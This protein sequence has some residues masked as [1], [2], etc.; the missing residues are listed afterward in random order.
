MVS[1]PLNSEWV[2][3][4]LNKTIAI[5]TLNAFSSATMQSVLVHVNAHVYKT[6]PQ[7]LP[8]Y[9]YPLRYMNMC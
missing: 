8:N 6:T 3:T 2:G 5:P 1:Y 7:I 9:M 4:W